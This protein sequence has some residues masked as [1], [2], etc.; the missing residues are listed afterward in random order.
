MT[1]VSLTL[2]EVAIFAHSRILVDF[3][4]TAMTLTPLAVSIGASQA[5]MG[6]DLGGTAASALLSRP[7]SLGT[8]LMGRFLGLWALMVAMVA[9]M[10][11]IFLAV[12]AVLGLP[13]TATLLWAMALVPV[14]C[15]IA[16]AIAMA[17]RCMG[18][19][20]V[21]AAAA[22][23]LV[24]AGYMTLN[25]AELH[26]QKHGPVAAACLRAVQATVP[27]MQRI[28]LRALAAQD[29]PVPEGFV[30][31]AILYGA[32]YSAGALLV[33]AWA[34]RRRRAL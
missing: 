1:A 8:W 23:L 14:E 16:M 15:T 27:Q 31:Y 4:L 24:G 20:T 2:S 34:L 26:Q 22:V 6:R 30:I 33:G 3:G 9:L 10:A 5:I 11:T 25:L 12:M 13:V 28:N 17:L 32:S 21:A 18:H 29:G 7:L 19:R